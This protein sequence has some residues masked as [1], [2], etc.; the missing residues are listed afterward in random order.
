MLHNQLIH[1]DP[2]DG[3]LVRVDEHCT[4]WLTVL[5]CDGCQTEISFEPDSPRVWIVAPRGP[6]SLAFGTSGRSK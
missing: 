6:N 3:E 5:R 4:L 2:C 1:E